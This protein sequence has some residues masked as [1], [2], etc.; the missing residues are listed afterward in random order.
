MPPSK[1]IVTTKSP[2]RFFFFIR[3]GLL[4]R[5]GEI[6]YNANDDSIDSNSKI[7]NNGTNHNNVPGREAELPEHDRG[8]ATACPA[9]CHNCC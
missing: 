7:N 9:Q 2:Q 4:L 1:L 5:G 3:G 8:G 6:T